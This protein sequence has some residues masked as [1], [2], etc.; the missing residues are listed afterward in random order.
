MVMLEP[1]KEGLIDEIAIKVMVFVRG[2]ITSVGGSVNL[3]M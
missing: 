1:I 2:A 3:E